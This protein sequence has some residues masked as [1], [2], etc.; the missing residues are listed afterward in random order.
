M[1]EFTETYNNFIKTITKCRFA[2]LTY[3]VKCLV[4][5]TYTEGTCLFDNTFH[6]QR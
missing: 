6:F 4:I 5:V 2:D 3:V 1:I